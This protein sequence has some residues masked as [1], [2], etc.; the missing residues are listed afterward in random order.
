VNKSCALCTRSRWVYC[1]CQIKILL[2]DMSE[3]GKMQLHFLAN[4]YLITRSFLLFELAR[5]HEVRSRYHLCGCRPLAR[6]MRFHERSI[7]QW[8]PRWNVKL[9]TR[10]VLVEGF[11]SH[12]SRCETLAW[13]MCLFQCIVLWYSFIVFFVFVGPTRFASSPS[14]GMSTVLLRHPM[15]AATA[16]VPRTPPTKSTSNTSYQPPDPIDRPQANTNHLSF[17]FEIQEHRFAEHL[18][19]RG[20]REGWRWASVTPRCCVDI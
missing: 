17:P 6:T 8:R 2:E 4:C 16:P 19:R 20:R 12:F 13:N 14:L 1:L 10:P 18:R 7:S 5:L 3:G 15:A 9:L 11:T